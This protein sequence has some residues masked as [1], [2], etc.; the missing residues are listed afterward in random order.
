VLPNITD[1]TS[2]S[3]IQMK[4]PTLIAIS[5]L[6]TTNGG[7]DGN[8]RDGRCS[9]KG[10]RGSSRRADSVRSCLRER[11]PLGCASAYGRS[12]CGSGGGNCGGGK[13]TSA[14]CRFGNR[15]MSEVPRDRLAQAVFE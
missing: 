8:R 10:I 14:W 7:V 1:P 12:R 5:R 6:L 4:R 13:L 2:P 15:T 11:L 3:V 9:S